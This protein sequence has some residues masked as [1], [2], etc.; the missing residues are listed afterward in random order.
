MSNDKIKNPIAVA[1][2]DKVKTKNDS[3]E[4]DPG[5]CTSPPST[6]PPPPKG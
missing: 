1:A 3:N 4:P 6:D 5:C 2:T